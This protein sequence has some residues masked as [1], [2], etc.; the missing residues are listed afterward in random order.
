MSQKVEIRKWGS[1]NFYS[2]KLTIERTERHHEYYRCFSVIDANGERKML[3]K[4]VGAANPFISLFD[5][6]KLYAIPTEKIISKPL[7]AFI[8]R[9][10]KSYRQSANIKTFKVEF[11]HVNLPEQ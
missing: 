6:F 10:L 3:W 8:V 11:Y 9:C 4:L 1:K 7:I 2:L 5:Q